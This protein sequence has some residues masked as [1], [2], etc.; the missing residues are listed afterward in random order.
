MMF[1]FFL[2]EPL[3]LSG[4]W[5]FGGYNFFKHNCL[6]FGDGI[7]FLANL[8]NLANILFFFFLF[9]F[10]IFYHDT[11][12]IHTSYLLGTLWTICLLL[13]RQAGSYPLWV[14]SLSPSVQSRS[15]EWG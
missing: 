4:I 6:R 13:S 11:Y 10:F 5:S 8:A 15:K 2:R 3:P 9:L 12:L 7:L 14:C 1:S